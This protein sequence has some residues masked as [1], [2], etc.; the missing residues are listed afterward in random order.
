MSTVAITG[1]TY[2][3][4]TTARCNRCQSK[5]ELSRDRQGFEFNGQAAAR[6]TD[7]ET[8]QKCGCMDCHWIYASDKQA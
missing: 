3:A 8:C 5:F 4:G 7:F 6:L 1:N 2:P